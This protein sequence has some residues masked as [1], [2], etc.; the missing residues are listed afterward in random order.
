MDDRSFDVL[1]ERCRWTYAV[2]DPSV[3]DWTHTMRVRPK[4]TD[5]PMRDARPDA[6]SR[7][8]VIFGPAGDRLAHADG[9]VHIVVLEED[10]SAATL[11]EARRVARDA[12]LVWSRD[13]TASAQWLRETAA[14]RPEVSLLVLAGDEPERLEGC[15]RAVAETTP[16][17]SAIEIAVVGPPA[18]GEVAHGWSDRLGLRR[19]RADPAEGAPALR[20]LAAAAATGDVLVFLDDRTRP[21]AGWLRPLVR[22]LRTEPDVGAVGGKLMTAR[23]AL[24][25][26]GGIVFT[27]GSIARFGHGS[28]DA[29]EATFGFVRDVHYVPADLFATRAGLLRVLGGFDDRLDE[30]YRAADYGLRVRAAGRRVIY[31][32]QAVAVAHEQPA[33]GTADTRTRFAKRW[34][35]ALAAMPR[36]PERLTAEAWDSLARVS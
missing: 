33:A 27:D 16:V 18:A 7:N 9:S 23:G 28:P 34:A 29:G 22:P 10:P 14:S 25:A 12:V 3:L 36:R 13:G 26:A 35:S 6:P 17:T 11:S 4:I 1:L 19:V 15:L 20:D 31:Q 21:L 24:D 8:T 2:E 32:P 30:G 5:P